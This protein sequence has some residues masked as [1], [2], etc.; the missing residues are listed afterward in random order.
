MVDTIEGG[1]SRGV[2]VLAT[3]LYPTI[4]DVGKLTT[5]LQNGGRHDG[6]QL[7]PAPR[8]A[9]ALFRASDTAGLPLGPTSRFG[10]PRYHLSFWSIPYR[11][12]AGCFFQIPYMSGYGGNTVMLLPNGVSAFRFADAMS[13]DNESLVLARSEEHT[14]EL[15]SLRHLV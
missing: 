4:D 7:L 1:G 10:V 15:Q 3:G 2:Q 12:G 8:I 9:D 6:R 14:S 13:Y 5:L 11:T